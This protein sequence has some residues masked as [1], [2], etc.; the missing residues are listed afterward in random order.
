M[1]PPRLTRPLI[2]VVDDDPAVR[3]SLTFSL[4]LDG[5]DV[6]IGRAHV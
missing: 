3:G 1:I 2:V 6:E 4:E 5:F